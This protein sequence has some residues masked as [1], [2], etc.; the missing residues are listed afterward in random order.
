MDEL[1]LAK[2]MLAE[3]DRCAD[4]PTMQA[5]ATAS[6]A[7]AAIAQAEQLKRIATATERRNELLAEFNEHNRTSAIAH[8][9]KMAESINAFL[10]AHFDKDE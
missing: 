8:T 1:E 5:F 4:I 2:Q 9:E 7:F 3:A 10:D 6:Q